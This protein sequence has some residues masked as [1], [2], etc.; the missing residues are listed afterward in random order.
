MCS[1]SKSNALFERTVWFPHCLQIP[2]SPYLLGGSLRHPPLPNRTDG[3]CYNTDIHVVLVAL[4]ACF[5]QFVALLNTP[6]EYSGFDVLPPDQ[7]LVILDSFVISKEVNWVIW[8]T[9]NRTY[10]LSSRRTRWKN[11]GLTS[12]S[13]NLLPSLTT[14]L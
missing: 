7:L 2:P 1:R 13:F 9:S 10:I 4:S 5:G 14:V 12:Q 11:H 8:H 6:A 3:P